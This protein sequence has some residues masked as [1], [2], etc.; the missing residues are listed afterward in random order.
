MFG[1]F[2][3]ALYLWLDERIKLGFFI[4]LLSKKQV[5]QHE[6]TFW[7]YFGGMALFLFLVQVATGLLLMVYYQPGIATSHESVSFIMEKVA[8]GQLMRSL[9]SWSA[10]LMIGIVFIHM[11][12]AYFM[13]AYRR[14]RELTWLSGFGLFVLSLGL[15]FSGYLLAWDQLAFFATKVGL[16]ILNSTPV[17]GPMMADLLRGGQDVSNATISRFFEL[18][19]WILPIAM[20]GLMGAHLLLVQ[21]HGMSTPYS[22][23]NKPK[24]KQKSMSFFGEF[25]FHDVFIWTLLMGA[26]VFVAWAFPWELGAKADPFAPAPEGIKP[27]W[28]FMFMFQILKLLPAHIGPFEGEVCGIV[29]FGVAGALW[30]LV[31]F[32]EGINTWTKKAATGY[33][34]VAVLVVVIGTL[35]GYVESPEAPLSTGNS[36]S[37]SPV[38]KGGSGQALFEQNCAACH[39]IGGPKRMGP[40]LKGITQKRQREPLI[41]FIVNPSG[42]AMP[43]LPGMDEATAGTILDYIE[44]QSNPQAA[45]SQDASTTKTAMPSQPAWTPQ[46]A[47]VGQKLFMGTMPFSKGGTA[48]LA[49]HTTTTAGALGGGTMGPDLTM[50]YTRLGEF[51]GLSAWM[52]AI[53]SA[54]M[55]PVYTQHPLTP[56]EIKALVAY[57]AQLDQAPQAQKPKAS[58][59]SPTA[60]FGLIGFMAL[61]LAMVAFAVLYNDRFRGVRQ[62]LVQDN[63]IESKQNGD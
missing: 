20:M 38:A 39:A 36:A 43:T 18:H 10:N 58:F 30:A 47:E 17:V 2:Q 8:F 44:A 40:D 29:A 57:F 26:L 60:K 54:T 9:H 23:A 25:L 55:K 1:R 11:F 61:V 14:P 16:Q 42:S 34:I 35:S 62:Q 24:S 37:V 22:Y 51:E 12:C 46:D 31:P 56:E 48:C 6:Q 63:R 52:N 41:A 27:E 3:E 5:P 19:I 4:K 28:Y 7:Y 33:G 32:W 50:V 45:T 59:L 13:R 15:G 49:C 21:L 53:P